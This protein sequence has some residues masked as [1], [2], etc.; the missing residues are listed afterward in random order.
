MFHV[1]VNLL[2]LQ[3]KT[4]LQEVKNQ[5]KIKNLMRLTNL[6]Q[7]MKISM[8]EINLKMQSNSNIMSMQI[9]KHLFQVS[10]MLTFQDFQTI[11]LIQ[12][13]LQQEVFLK[14]NNISIRQ[15]DHL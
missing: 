6:S 15:G 5:E 8:L 2:L 3:E 1:E 9:D 14:V 7:L 4:V 13:F 12:M 11:L 10:Q